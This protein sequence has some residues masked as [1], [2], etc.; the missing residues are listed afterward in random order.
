MYTLLK[1]RE[2]IVSIAMQISVLFAGDTKNSSYTNLVKDKI[3]QNNLTSICKILHKDP[4]KYIKFVK[5]RLY[6]DRRYSISTNKIRKLGWKPE[7]SLMEDL[8][9]I[10]DWY[11]NN[12]KLFKK[13]IR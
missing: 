12:M 8:P 9:E 10:V 13:F 1:Y 4:K 5:D 7:N 11:N 6:N 2:C 3:Y